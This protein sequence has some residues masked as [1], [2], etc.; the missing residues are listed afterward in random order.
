MLLTF[1]DYEL[2]TRLFALRCGGQVCQVEPLVFNLL[3]YLA[4]HRE[5]IVTRQELMDTLWAGKVVSDSTLGSCIKAAR[6]AVG[7][8]GEVQGCIA[9]VHRRGY[10]FVAPVEE[11]EAT[12]SPSW[13]RSSAQVDASAG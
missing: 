1:R 10:R 12:T 2:D 8:N 7:D 5:R 6:K 9:T 13:R 4:Q 3:T 11:R